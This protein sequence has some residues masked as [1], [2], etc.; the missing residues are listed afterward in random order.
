MTVVPRERKMVLSGKAK[1][2]P[3]LFPVQK[4]SCCLY[5]FID[6]ICLPASGA[7]PRIMGPVRNDWSQL[8][9]SRGKV[10]ESGQESN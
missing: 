7:G 1:V 4:V 3:K 10:E 9:K 2:I 8:T 6:V 5:N